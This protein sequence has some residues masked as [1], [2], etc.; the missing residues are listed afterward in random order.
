MRDEKIAAE[1][2]ERFLRLDPKNAYAM[3]ARACAY[4]AAGDFKKAIEWQKKAMEDEDFMKDDGVLGGQSA[5][6]RIAKWEAEE[7]WLMP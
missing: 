7:L 1:L 4:A 3:N 2:A 6:E 5:K